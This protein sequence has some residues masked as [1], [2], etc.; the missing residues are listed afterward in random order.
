MSTSAR[1]P[2]VPSDAVFD[3]QEGAWQVG[4]RDALG[5]L[6]GDVVVFRDDGTPRLRYTCRAGRREGPFRSFHPHGGLASEGRYE[7]GKPAGVLARYASDAPGSEPLRNCCVPPGATELRLHYREGQVAR[8]EFRDVEGRALRPD[9]S[10]LPIQPVGVP[11]DADY[12]D[13]T[14][15][16]I[17]RRRLD[18]E[19]FQ[20][21]AFD[22]HGECREVVEFVDGK[23]RRRRTYAPGVGLCEDSHFD[24]Q[25]RRHGMFFRRLD[26]GS[27]YADTSIQSEEGFFEHGHPVG[28]WSLKAGDREVRS[29]S[30]G[31][32]PSEAA[33]LDLADI[34]LTEE[35][36]VRCRQEAQAALGTD[37]PREALWWAARALAYDATDATFATLRDALV[38]PITSAQQEA[39]DQTL[40]N[41]TRLSTLDVLDT[42]FAGA[43]P[44]LALRTLASHLPVGTPAAR[45]F[46]EASMRLD[47]NDPR[48]WAHRALLR[49]DTGEP[50]LAQE[51]IEEL[52]RRGETD[53]VADLRAASRILFPVWSFRCDVEFTLP[54]NR[55]ALEMAV[56]QPLAAIQNTLGVY[57]TRLATVRRALATHTGATA[58]P[59]FPPDTGQFLPKGDLELRSFRAEIIDDTEDGE[60]RVE[61]EID[62]AMFLNASRCVRDLMITARADWDAMSWLCWAAG[63]ETLSLPE[64]LRPPSEFAPM[65]NETMLRAWRAL[66]QLR[67]RG[68]VSRN[69]GIPDFVWEGLGIETLPR[70]MAEIASRQYLER[71]ALFLWLLFPQN[72]SPFQSD[73]RQL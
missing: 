33:L 24:E 37:R 60:E 39:W 36:S 20:T 73:L 46:V 63:L 1:P 25:G 26:E 69:R 7:D 14:A 42:L 31:R 66:D 38:V 53:A 19:R 48:T 8:E 68:L 49:L 65:V 10:Q 13:R 61:V 52:E 23:M 54:P 50:E 40:L 18:A 2:G 34:E 71:R 62:E 41:H 3:A 43:A 44:A 64:S 58:R 17:E 15:R 57:A 22:E 45:D 55:E 70:G 16:W 29:L 30:R 51:D 56:A 27:P 72:V 21:R 9:G 67:T 32:L 28:S 6:E 59:W 4:M 35:G 11:E 12:D 47:A 5:R